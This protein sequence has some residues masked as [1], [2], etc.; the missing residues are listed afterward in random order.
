MKQFGE[1]RADTLQFQITYSDG[2]FR[3]TFVYRGPQQGWHFR[4]ESGDGHGGWKLFANYE[5]T[6]A[7]TGSKSR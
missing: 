6:P 4:L 5:I 3:D 7:T 1:A 2:P